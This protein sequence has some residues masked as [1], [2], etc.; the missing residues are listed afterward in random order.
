[1]LVQLT[2]GSQILLSGLVIYDN[3]DDVFCGNDA[4]QDVPTSV[5]ADPDSIPGSCTIDQ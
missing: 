5:L 4:C 2:D 1:M 3:T